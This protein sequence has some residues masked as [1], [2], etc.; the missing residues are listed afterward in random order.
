MHRE[1]SYR[2]LLIVTSVTLTLGAATH[3]A[4]P[5]DLAPADA[6]A[7]T[8]AQRDT[9]T[10]Q[11]LR[12]TL[13]RPRAEAGAPARSA[14]PYFYIPGSTEVGADA[15][16]LKEAFADVDVAGVIAQVKLRQVYRN[17]GRET[18]EA[19]YVFPGSTR[20]A[21]YAMKMRIGARVIEADIRERA[22]ARQDYEQAKRQGRTASLLEQQRPNVFQ[23]NVANI[24]P[25]DTI[26]VE[27]FYTEL[28]VPE[29]RV[30][31]LVIPTVV[32]PRYNDGSQEEAPGARGWVANPHLKQGQDAPYTFGARID[33]RAGL[34]ISRVRTS[35]DV[36]VSYG[37]RDASLTL[38][39][40]PAHGNRD[41]IVHYALSD[42]EIQSG[43]MLYPGG[44][45]Q[46]FLMMVEPPARVQPRDLVS[47][48]YLFIL[49]VSGS[50]NGFPLDVSKRLMQR[51]LDQLGPQDYFNVLF[52]AGDSALLSERSL[53]VSRANLRRARD[54]VDM[55][56]GGGGTALVPAL[57]RA[58]ELP[59]PD[60]DMARVVVI[61]T[62]GY[63]TV[64][65]KA[66]SL[67]RERLGDASFF[68][69]GIGS[70]VN[71]F[72]IEGMA[73]AGQGEPFVVT[74]AADAE[75]AAE[76]FERYISAPL[77]TDVQVRFDGLDVY[78]VEPV[79]LPDLYAERPVLVYGKY[80]GEAKGSVTLSG[81]AAGSTLDLTLRVADADRAEENA[82]LRYLW[83]R[84][85][86][87][88]LSDDAALP[89][90]PG[91]K[92]KITRLGL[93]YSL[94]TQHTSFVAIDSEVRASGERTRKVRQPLPMP[95]GVSNLAV[96]RNVKISQGMG[97][98]GLGLRGTGK[99]GG[100]SASGTFGVGSVGTRGRGGAVGVGY[101][102][103]VGAL[104]GSSGYGAA[105][106]GLGGL[107]GRSVSV[108]KIHAG[109]VIVRGSISK[110]EIQRV[111]RQHH[112]QV[113]TCYQRAL[114]R[115]PAL[116]GRVVVQLTIDEHGR[117]TV[118]KIKSSQLG[119]EAVERCV[120][121]IVRQLRFAV[122]AGGGE[123]VVNYPFVFKP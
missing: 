99:G 71:R 19:V 58:L 64:E 8:I 123:V 26:E 47:R 104:Q 118:A 27:L 57:E 62:D 80:R 2:R 48:E 92:A 115:D 68:P 10:T 17:D 33:L 93:K 41:L 49:D 4:P 50:M 89:G 83:A 54:L 95:A 76:R 38:E 107:R 91:D 121:R 3:A 77:L 46:F 6:R 59:R 39:P 96:G 53:P 25:G 12:A 98:G 63:V 103:G 75:E 42:D 108:P 111:F 78:D 7:W 51:M 56:Q 36:Q 1:R 34:P 112:K 9:T 22:R 86:V 28:L 101:G 65:K 30:Y 113:R 31:E 120:L 40:D 97:F 116:A 45:E 43:L 55:Q 85:R 16:P 79:V 37:A 106:G 35:H 119:D 100:G 82:A 32:G 66:F 105:A 15:L 110:Q 13:E 70:S 87:Q 52:F 14:A 102:S 20:A 81:A 72:L 61:A 117:V 90:A 23:M 94:L 122:P 69:F 114:Q 18:L 21:V 11:W 74:S 88:R 60:A 109:K 29:E 24:L 44:D 84:R 5:R 67:I 73:R